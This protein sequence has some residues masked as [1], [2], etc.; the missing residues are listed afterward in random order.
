[1]KILYALQATG[2]GHISRAM[3]LLPFLQNYGTVDLF[4]SGANSTL[5]LDAPVKYRSQGLSLFYTCKGSLD[6]WK[7]TRSIS[8]FRM[9]KEARD[10][11]VEKYDLVL[12]DFECITSIACAKK[13]VPSVNF[14]HQASFLSPKTPRPEKPSKV[15]EWVLQN[16]AKASQYIGLHF[17]SYDDFIYSPVIK[18]EILQAEP[19]NDGHITVYL[20]SYCDNELMALLAPFKDHRFEV[21]SR[22]TKAPRTEGNI[23]LTPVNKENFN[24]SL[25][26]CHGI[27][28]GAGFETPAE[29]I[30]LRKKMIAIPIQGQYEQQCNAAALKKIG[31]KTLDKLD[32]DF[33]DTFNDWVNDPHTPTISYKYST[34]AII[35]ILMMRCTNLRY[36]LDIPYP[37]LIFN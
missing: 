13:K 15:G 36:E 1:M 30:H 14:G 9:M 12:N 18:T 33:P 3:E 17:E 32:D 25:I 23:T 37:D 11:P 19:T 20:P 34:E 4:L 31:I 2:N 5:P 8:P 16:Y 21:F 24:Q 27:I 10:L 6:Y 35:N 29:A 22:Q 28:C 7:L 26:S